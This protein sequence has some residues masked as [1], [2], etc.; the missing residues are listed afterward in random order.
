LVV[1]DSPEQTGLGRGRDIDAAAA[2]AGCDGTR[3]V[4]IKLESNRPRHWASV[5]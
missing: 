1:V 2:K 5:P 4:L 3:A